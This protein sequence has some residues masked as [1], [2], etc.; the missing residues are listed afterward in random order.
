MITR[1]LI[2]AMA[3]MVSSCSHIKGLPSSDKLDVHQY[4]SYILLTYK[5]DRMVE[6]ELIA[7]DSTQI[8]VLSESSQKCVAVSSKD[9]K[10]YT[11]YYADHKRYGW[12]FPLFLTYPVIHG[13]LSAISIP[14]HL[15]ITSSVIASSDKAFTYTENTL[16]YDEL[17]MFARFPQNI[18]PN[19]ELVNIK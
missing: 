10:R 4:G 15:I 5:P 17:K 8:V 14:I 7:V 12:T 9:V 16:K 3:L 18:P 19:V 13:M 6:G 2:P 11:V 1:V